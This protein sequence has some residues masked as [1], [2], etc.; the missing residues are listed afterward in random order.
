MPLAARLGKRRSAP[1]NRTAGEGVEEQRAV[2]AGI[3]RKR[4]DHADT[5]GS[6][7]T[8]SGLRTPAARPANTA[9]PS[10]SCL[11]D[12]RESKSAEPATLGSHQG[13]AVRPPTR[14]DDLLV[15]P[16]DVGH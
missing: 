9:R 7:K 14:N 15:F 4:H 5:I 8:P 13:G 10:G 1:V 3:G 2:Q 11:L 12:G 16:G 6:G